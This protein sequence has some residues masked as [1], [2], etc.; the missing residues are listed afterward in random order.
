MLLRPDQ[1]CPGSRPS[2]KLPRPERR[3]PSRATNRARSSTS[4]FVN[5]V[6]DHDPFLAR[7]IE[8]APTSFYPGDYLL[9]FFAAES[10]GRHKFRRL[11]AVESDG[12]A[13]SALHS[14]EELREFSLRF[15]S[16]DYGCGAHDS[17]WPD[18]L[19]GQ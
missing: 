13:L 7:R 19:T 1:S 3:K 2:R 18:N 6:P 8:H 11:L 14:V 15:G 17:T 12:K 10:L 9:D 5:Q 4:A 16:S